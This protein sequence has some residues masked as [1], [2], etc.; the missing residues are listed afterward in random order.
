MPNA[1]E[2]PTFNHVGGTRS[3]NEHIAPVNT[4]SSGPHPPPIIDLL[5]Y[6]LLN[7]GKGQLNLNRDAWTEMI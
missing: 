1:V 7:S 2:H 5:P 6:S 4:N 3:S